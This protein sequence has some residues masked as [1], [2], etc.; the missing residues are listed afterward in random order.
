[1]SLKYNTKDHRVKNRNQF[2]IGSQL[3]AA[4]P[5][6]RVAG[7]VLGVSFAALLIGCATGS[8]SA[9]LKSEQWPVTAKARAEARWGVIAK[10][11]Y[12]GAMAYFTTASAKDYTP[13]TLAAVWQPLR[14]TGGVAQGVNCDETGCDVTVNVS[15]SVRLPRVG[16]KQ[17]IVPLVERWVPENGEMR[18]IRR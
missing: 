3:V 2:A 13:K 9:S 6:V 7:C 16:F 10:G 8:G 14:P 15:M 12:D 11:D 5:Q 17:Q 1:M 4:T 18:L